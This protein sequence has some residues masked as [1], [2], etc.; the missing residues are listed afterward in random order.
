MW[1]DCFSEWGAVPAGVP[2]GTKLGPWLFIVM[3]NDLDISNTELWKHVDDTTISEP[4]P[5]S[6]SSKIPSAVDSLASSA[7]AN[8]FQLN[9][10][11]CKELR[12]NSSTKET[13][14]DPIVVNEEEIELVSFAK[15]LGLHISCDV[16]WN[17]HIDY[18]INKRTNVCSVCV[19]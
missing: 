4:V 3:I 17:A 8:K 1:Q 18:I 2:Q 9:E 10:S 14:F 6:A 5:K 7:A 13:I 11:K 15:I 19:N 12:I 16:K